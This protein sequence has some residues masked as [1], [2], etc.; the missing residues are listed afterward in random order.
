MHKPCQL[1]IQ[2]AIITC[3]L[4]FSA[5]AQ[6]AYPAPVELIEQVDSPPSQQSRRAW[7][8]TSLERRMM[9]KE[10]LQ[11]R[12]RKRLAEKRAGSTSAS[13]SSTV[14]HASKALI[15][16]PRRPSRVPRYNPPQHPSY[17]PTYQMLT[18][19]GQTRA[20]ATPPIA[21]T[22]S[23]ARHAAPHIYS[24]APP[25]PTAQPVTV[26]TEAVSPPET[27]ISQ[28]LDA[29]PSLP[30][31]SPD[32]TYEAASHAP[33]TDDSY[34]TF[35]TEDAYASKSRH[36]YAR[37]D[38][39][40]GTSAEPPLATEKHSRP[41]SPPAPGK[42][43]NVSYFIPTEEDVPQDLPPEPLQPLDNTPSLVNTPSALSQESQEIL[44][45]L[46]EDITGI[47]STKSQPRP[48][49][50]SRTDPSITLPET[51]DISSHEEAGMSVIVRKHTMN[52]NHELEKAYMA[53]IAG[54]SDEAIRI[55][56]DIL[57]AAPQNKLALFGLGT[58]YHRIGMFDKARPLYGRLLKLDPY[59][60]EALNNFLALIGEESPKDALGQLER[61]RG[62]N[63]DF[64]P[65]PAQ[66]AL[67]YRRIHDYDNAIHL[68]QEAASLSPENLVYKYNLAIM[69]DTAGKKR[70][71]AMLYKQLLDA[72]YRGEKIPADPT[73]LQERLTFL[74]SNKA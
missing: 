66:M 20:I 23:P 19:P 6:T 13:H 67:I 42:E 28:P 65:I 69:Y 16:T 27:V 43:I 18:R 24:Y 72:R 2:P 33:P 53:L 62:K 29:P 11:E 3:L 10:E 37:T 26:T 71:A 63:P 38:V 15:S 4:T 14:H 40:A 46:P 7:R 25:S 5:S 1:L 58:T 31:P 48:V 68:M 8:S 30:A 9:L 49:S 70:E 61:L 60:K 12:V 73:H 34:L 32:K 47:S 59:H 74:V 54:A 22:A 17:Q 41:P 55:Y 56:R 50:I 45:S 52:A 39:S 64:S 21:E 57:D 36:L 44:Y 51:D 35:P